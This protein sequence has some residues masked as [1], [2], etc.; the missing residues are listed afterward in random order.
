MQRAHTD[1]VRYLALAPGVSLEALALAVKRF[2]GRV[3]LALEGL[4]LT[5]D[6]VALLA[7]LDTGGRAVLD[8]RALDPAQAHVVDELV[9]RGLVAL[10]RTR[11]GHVEIEITR[12]GAHALAR[13]RERLRSLER[14]L[15]EIADPRELAALA[16]RLS[17]LAGEPR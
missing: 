6:D 5:T 3:E 1:A 17:T 7:R 10:R 14:T 15:D 11:V 12:D 13:A 4:A 2:V 8:D 16:V 9:E